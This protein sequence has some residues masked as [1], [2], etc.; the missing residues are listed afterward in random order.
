MLPSLL[1]S[2][3]FLRYRNCC[4]DHDWD[5]HSNLREHR[6]FCKHYHKRHKTFK[7]GAWTLSQMHL[8]RSHM[9]YTGTHG[10]TNGLA[11][12]W[13]LAESDAKADWT[14]EYL[15]FGQLQQAEGTR[16]SPGARLRSVGAGTT[17]WGGCW[18]VRIVGGPLWCHHN[19]SPCRMQLSL[20]V[21][22]WAIRVLILRMLASWQ[23]RGLAEGVS[24]SYADTHTHWTTAS[25]Q[26]FPVLQSFLV[27]VDYCVFFPSLMWVYLTLPF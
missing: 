22:F 14:L 4:H 5:G 12:W 21:I 24:H 9:K 20:A 17:S 1:H 25:N 8:W 7:D 16:R 15:C 13:G 18:E 26:H 10:F 2:S 3:S 19:V 27:L 11:E 23:T 6:V